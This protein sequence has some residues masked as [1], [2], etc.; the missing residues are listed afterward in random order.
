MAFAIYKPESHQY[1]KAK[2]VVLWRSYKNLK[3]IRRLGLLVL[4]GTCFS[5]VGWIAQFVGLSQ[6]H[7][8]AILVQLGATFIMVILRSSIRSHLRQKPE[9]RPL[10]TGFEMDDLVLE[11]AKLDSWSMCHHRVFEADD[12]SKSSFASDI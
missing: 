11:T 7:W 3:S 6:L 8:S 10:K 2:S 1:M 9:V 4:V 12:K 5:L